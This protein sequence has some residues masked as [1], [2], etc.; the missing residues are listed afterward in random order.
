MPPQS[1]AA[2]EIRPLQFWASYGLSPSALADDGQV[3][4]W[5]QLWGEGEGGRS[6]ARCLGR[7]VSGS[8]RHRWHKHCIAKGSICPHLLY[9]VGLFRPSGERHA[10]AYASNKPMHLGTFGQ[11]QCQFLCYRSFAYAPTRI[12]MCNWVGLPI[13]PHLPSVFPRTC[14][15]LANQ[16]RV[17]Y[18]ANMGWAA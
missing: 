6:C 12:A 18:W 14:Q 4:S 9:R 11:G 17:D 16:L 13:V 7:Y 10:H 3:E 5:I 2:W 8:H 15:Y 1:Q